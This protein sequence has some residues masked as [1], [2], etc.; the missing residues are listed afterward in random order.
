MDP[1]EYHELVEKYKQESRKY[2]VP[3]SVVPVA[4]GRLKEETRC[5]I[6]YGM[7]KTARV[8]GCLHRY[9]SDCIGQCLRVEI[10]G[11]QP[12]AKECPVCRSHLGSRRAAKEN[13]VYD[14]I[15]QALYGDLAMFEREEEK[16]IEED[17]KRRMKAKQL[18]PFSPR[19]RAMSAKGKVAAKD[20]NSVKL[21]KTVKPIKQP[22]IKQLAKKESSVVAS[23]P[24]TTHGKRKAAAPAAEGVKAVK[25]RVAE[26]GSSLEEQN[27]KHKKNAAN[28]L[29]ASARAASIR[30]T[31]AVLVELQSYHAIHHHA[32]KLHYPYIICLLSATVRDLAAFVRKGMAE[33]LAGSQHSAESEATAHPGS[34]SSSHHASK[35]PLGTDLI[36]FYQSTH[37]TT[38]LTSE[39]TIL[40][41]I[42]QGSGSGLGQ[43]VLYFRLVDAAVATSHGSAHGHQHAHQ[44]SHAHAHH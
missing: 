4:L 33:G 42:S 36:E 14:S 29:A 5:P 9:C 11:R 16:L 8:A 34:V 35:E 44:H 24:D 21:P 1:Q 40:Q 43:L 18:G 25:A 12:E 41:L 38:A 17:N 31:E 2:F 30:S 37:C 26:P 15:I 13:P 22:G 39:T 6:C 20:P 10:P 28:L 23:T 27:E 32:Y 19:D 7:I 3:G